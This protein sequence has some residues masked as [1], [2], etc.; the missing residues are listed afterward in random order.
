MYGPNGPTAPAAKTAPVASVW[1]VR[2]VQNWSLPKVQGDLAAQRLD[3]AQ[4]AAL[5]RVLAGGRELRD[6]DRRQNAQDDH[7][8]QNFDQGEALFGTNRVHVNA[9]VNSTTVL[10]FR[11]GRHEADDP[12]RTVYSVLFH[13]GPA[14]AAAAFAHFDSGRSL[15]AVPVGGAGRESLATGRCARCSASF[16]LGR[17]APDVS[18]IGAVRGRLNARVFPP[19]AAP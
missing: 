14:P 18:S 10:V 4:Q 3:G 11:G 6:D 8:D 17:F 15:T 1:I 5:A 2:S 12:P 19:R 9:S 13:F 16:R 7:H